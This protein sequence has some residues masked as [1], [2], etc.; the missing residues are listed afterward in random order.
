MVTLTAPYPQLYVTINLPD[1]EFGDS[2]GNPSQMVSKY[3][4]TGNLYTHKKT[5]QNKKLLFEFILS[6]GR[7][8]ALIEFIKS[9]LSSK[10]KINDHM[11][12]IW[13]GYIITDPIS[14][15]INEGEFVSVEFEFEGEEV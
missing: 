14:F 13:L 7:A 3:T 4:M 2:I 9:Y 5:N 11:G 12:K 10:I 8:A 1:P 15:E 6:R